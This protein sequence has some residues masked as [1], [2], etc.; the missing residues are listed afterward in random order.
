MEE[1]AEQYAARKQREAETQA[2]QSKANDVADPY[3]GQD[4]R[5][6]KGDR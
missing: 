3:N 1:T 4:V 6:G 2:L 5:S